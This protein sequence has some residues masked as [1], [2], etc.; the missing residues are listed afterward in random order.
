MTGLFRFFGF[1]AFFLLC[2]YVSG[3]SQKVLKTQ[4]KQEQVSAIKKRLPDG[5]INGSEEGY[6]KLSR[7]M[8]ALYD[9]GYLSASVDTV[10]QVA[11]TL[12]A[13][14]FPGS[15]FNWVKLKNG[16][17]DEGLLTEAGFREKFYDGKPL[18]PSGFKSLNSRILEYCE[19]HGYPFASLFYREFVFDSTGVSATLFLDTE[20]Q[21]VID[22]VIVK[23]TSRLSAKYLTNYLSV[24]TGDLY[25]ESV[26]RKVGSRVKELPMV[27]E[28]R[29]FSV[30]FSEDKARLILALDDKKASQI[31]GVVGVLPPSSG[32]GKVQV[33][34]DVRIRLLSSFGRGELFDLN[35]KQPQ[36]KT[37]DLKVKLNY[38]FLFSTPFGADFNLGIYKKDTSYVEVVLGAG[39]QFLL[40]GGDYFKAFVSNKKSSLL[41]TKLYENTTVLPPF[42][43]VEVTSYGIS[44]K[45]VKLDYRL[46]PRSGYTID[47]TASAGNKT[48][49]KNGKLNPAVYDSLQ[50]KSVQYS[51]EIQM[52][53]YLPVFKRN[54]IDFGIAGGGLSGENTFNN[55]LFRFGG[56]RTLRGFDEESLTASLFITGKIE[57]RYLLEENSY[58]FAF[59]NQAWYERNTRTDYIQDQ[60]IGFGAGITFETRLGIFSFNYALGKE[61]DNPI[62]FKAAKVH[63]G[64]INYF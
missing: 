39:V 21:V 14:C 28:L 61:F 13:E 20:R 8:V 16:N 18:T 26:I 19:N 51:G 49:S 30:V 47:V 43:D 46:N 12:I 58:F 45:S 36:A 11:D 4:W 31:D 38:P 53:Y 29:P 33:T 2:C 64:L 63:F 5:A 44:F 3:Y 27:T 24:K 60:P 6:R 57:L 35:W 7:F 62:R 32:T 40:K 56:L 10:Y 37:Q 52:D 1:L 17:L 48:I 9:L 54:V 22:S 41:A 59:V 15:C 25:N 23:G 34:G 55:E 50:L 42:A